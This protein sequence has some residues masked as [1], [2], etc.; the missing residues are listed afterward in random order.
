MAITYSVGSRS[1]VPSFQTSI[2]SFKQ[3]FCRL[4][5]A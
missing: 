5:N 3:K 4:L 2:P 1:G